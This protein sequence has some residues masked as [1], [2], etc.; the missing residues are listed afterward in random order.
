MRR[1][2]HSSP[3]ATDGGAERELDADQLVGRVVEQR[4]GH[5]LRAEQGREHDPEARTAE[6]EEV[7]EVHD[8][9][10]IECHRETERP[11]PRLGVRVLRS[12]TRRRRACRRRPRAR[13]QRA[14]T[15]APTPARPGEQVPA[16]ARPVVEARDAR[17][18]DGRR[19][20]RDQEQHA[21]ADGRGR[22]RARLVPREDDPRDEQ[23]AVDER[24]ERRQPDRRAGVDA[25]GQGLPLH[26]LARQQRPQR[27]AR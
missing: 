13:A 26:L 5:E 8:R 22:V 15:T 20:D 19:G 21:G 1:R 4:V 23:V 24:P 12:R 14:P 3:A 6:S 7:V 17:E 25:R 18:E 9:Q 11:E 16:L 10:A 2:Y 27:P